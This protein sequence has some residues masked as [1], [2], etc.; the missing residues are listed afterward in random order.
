ML[1]PLVILYSLSF[2]LDGIVCH[3]ILLLQLFILQQPCPFS[4]VNVRVDYFNL[5]ILK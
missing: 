4:F 1:K 2:I 5:H 3:Y